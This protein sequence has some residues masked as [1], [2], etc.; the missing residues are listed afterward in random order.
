MLACHLQNQRVDR[1][2]ERKQRPPF[3]RPVLLCSVMTYC[4]GGDLLGRIT[5][6]KGQLFKENLIMNWFVQ[7]ALAIAYMHANK[8]LHRDIKTGAWP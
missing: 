3:R 4:D 7:I 5:A 1:V 6:Q 8:V 2:T